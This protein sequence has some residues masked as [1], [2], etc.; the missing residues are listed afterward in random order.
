MTDKGDTPRT[1][2]SLGL[3]DDKDTSLGFPSNWNTCQRSSPIATPRFEHQAEFCL[4][5]KYGECPLF[6]SQ[7]ARPMPQALRNPRNSSDKTGNNSLR[8]F[9][10]ALMVFVAVLAFGWKAAAGQW[11]SSPLIAQATWTAS[12]SEEPALL[13][14]SPPTISVSVISTLT[15]ASSAMET[16]VT[17]PINTLSKNRLEVPIG[18]QYKFVIHKILEGETMDQFAAQFNTSVE[19]I[20]AVNY[21]RKN[22]GW[23]GTLLVIPFG[24]TD[25]AKLPSFVVYQVAENDRGT[26]VEKLAKSLRV[27][28]LDLKYYN[29]WTNDGD[30]P[31]VGDY[32]LVPR[33]RPNP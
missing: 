16:S 3:M 31:L 28:P 22:P 7:Q 23:S 21:S 13:L 18:T 2:P 17:I 1:C 5:G 27:A 30:R 29:G 6:L 11:V 12:P 15:P 32:L 20:V 8:N 10:I 24:F 33:L 4:G 19:A 25:F 14:L 26:S 9:G